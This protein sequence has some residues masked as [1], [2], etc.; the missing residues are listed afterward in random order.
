MWKPIMVTALMFRKAVIMI[1][2]TTINKVQAI[3]NSIYRYLLGVGGY[4]KI[5]ALKGDIGA[6]RMETRAIEAAHGSE[7]I[8]TANEYRRELNIS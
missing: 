6:S 7:W 2:K 1:A 8:R 3:E 4:T 5:S